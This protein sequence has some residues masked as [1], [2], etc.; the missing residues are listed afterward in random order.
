MFAV[1][2]QF[3]ITSC[4]TIISNNTMSSAFTTKDNIGISTSILVIYYY[5]IISFMIYLI[6]NY[7]ILNIMSMPVIVLILV[8]SKFSVFNIGI[9]KE[10]I[11]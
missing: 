10:K 7:S 3:A 5:S 11:K 2:M 8:V 4:A 9:N 6:S 1:L